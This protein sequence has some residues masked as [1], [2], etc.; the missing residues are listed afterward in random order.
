MTWL[1]NY[2]ASVANTPHQK[3][4][5]RLVEGRT[6]HVSG[7]QEYPMPENPTVR[8]SDVPG[9]AEVAYG[10]QTCSVCGRMSE[11]FEVMLKIGFPKEEAIICQGCHGD[12]ILWAAR[13]AHAGV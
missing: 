11:R 9:M 8:S 4:E 3:L 5:F 13:Q 7:F 6:Y 12:A 10:V 2:G 1:Q